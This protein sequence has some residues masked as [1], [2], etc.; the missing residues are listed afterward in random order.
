MTT[1]RYHVFAFFNRSRV[2]SHR[3]YAA[4]AHAARKLSKMKHLWHPGEEASVR[5]DHGRTI[6]PVY[7]LG[8]PR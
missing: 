1:T 2:S 5:D 8:F 3:T 7:L 4:A 6:G